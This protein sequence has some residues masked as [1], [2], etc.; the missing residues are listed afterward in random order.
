MIRKAQEKDFSELLKIA[1]ND[2]FKHPNE[3]SLEWVNTRIKRGDEF[4]VYEN[5]RGVV[6]FIC[7]QQ[8]FSKGCRLHFISVMKEEQGKG[9]GT[10]LVE[11]TKLLTRDL[12]KD[13]LYLYVYQDNKKAFNFYMKH[14][15]NFSGIFLDKYGEGEHAF[16]MCSN[17]SPK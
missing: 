8:Q 7:F 15:F 4:Y 5:E 6:G 12:G 11:K 10:A 17:I 16:L 2:G 9:I 3:M 13:K 14:G 1:M